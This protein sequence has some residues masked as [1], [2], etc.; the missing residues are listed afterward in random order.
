MTST[1]TSDVDIIQSRQNDAPSKLKLTIHHQSPG[2]ELISPV[3][4]IGGATCYLMPDQRLNVGSTTQVGFNID[5]NQEESIGT[6]MYKIQ[7]NNIDQSN[8]NSI[9][10]ENETCIQL[11]ITWKVYK[12]GKFYVYPF[13]IEHDKDRVL[14]RDELVRLAKRYKLSNIQRN[15]IEYTRLIHDNL[16]LMTGVTLSN[17]GECC[18]IDVTI[19]EASINWY[20]QKLRYNGLDR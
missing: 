13:L 20:I 3:Y 19:S 16:M 15:S 11:A 2:I 9:S 10:N 12:S 6:L 18:K 7:R 1:Y 17:E 5:P 14:D 8:E 4:T